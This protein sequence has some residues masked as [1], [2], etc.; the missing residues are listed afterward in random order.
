LH[1]SNE[2]PSSTKPASVIVG[3]RSRTVD[4]ITVLIVVVSLLLL[5]VASYGAW[6]VKRLQDRSET[7]LTQNVDSIRTAVDDGR[8]E[9]GPRRRGRGNS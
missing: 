6:H 3:E 2:S 5:A 9:S 4:R 7:M 1:L 8:R